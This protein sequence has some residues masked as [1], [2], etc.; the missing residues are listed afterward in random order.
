METTLDMYSLLQ[1]QIMSELL[2][3]SVVAS[4]LFYLYF[5]TFVILLEKKIA[6]GCNVHMRAHTHTM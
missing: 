2:N 5:T 3:S 4:L 1:N 6:L